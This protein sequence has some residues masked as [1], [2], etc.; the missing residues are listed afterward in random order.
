MKLT[1]KVP[2]AKTRQST[3]FRWSDRVDRKK[4][5]I[6]MTMIIMSD[7]MLNTALVIK[8]LVAALH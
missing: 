5:G 1:V 8:W 2:T 3:T 7:E 4:M 6:G